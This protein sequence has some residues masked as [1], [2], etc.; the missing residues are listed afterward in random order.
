MGSAQH[1]DL[2]V[3]ARAGADGSFEAVDA[4]HLGEQGG[5]SAST[6][7]EN[8]RPKLSVLPAI[9]QPSA[10]LKDELLHGSGQRQRG[11]D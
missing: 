1:G 3:A 4:F 2:E 9:D 11:S 6:C 7:T 8:R 5:A 10:I